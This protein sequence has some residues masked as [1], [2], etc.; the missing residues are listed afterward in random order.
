MSDF[1]RSLRAKRDLAMAR[2]ELRGG[3]VYIPVAERLPDEGRE[4]LIWARMPQDTY[5]YRVKFP[6]IYWGGQ[7]F[8]AASGTQ[9]QVEVCGWNYRSDLRA[10]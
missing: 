4:C 5:P 1:E 9:I 2:P 10:T 7:W 3:K 8:N 6:V